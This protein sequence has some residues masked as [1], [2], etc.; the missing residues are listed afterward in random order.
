M[1]KYT[2]VCGCALTLIHMLVGGESDSN[3]VSRL[4]RCA[5]VVRNLKS[6]DLETQR[7]ATA[8]LG[9]LDLVAIPFLRAELRRADAGQHRQAMT[10]QSDALKAKMWETNRPRVANWLSAGRWDMVNELLSTGHGKEATPVLE[11]AAKE[12]GVLSVAFDIRLA[13]LQDPTKPRTNASVEYP[14]NPA[15]LAKRRSSDDPITE[16]K[17]VATDTLDNWV[18]RAEVCRLS[19]KF[20]NGCFLAVRSRLTD[21]LPEDYISEWHRSNLFVNN[22]FTAREVYESLVICDGDFNLNGRLHGIVSSLV[23]CNGDFIAD[24]NITPQS[25]MGSVIYATGDITFPIKIKKPSGSIFFAGGKVHDGKAVA[26]AKNVHEGVTEPPFNVR[27]LDPKEFG[28]T[29]DVAKGGLTVAKLDEKSAF[30]KQ[31]LK[32]GDLITHADDL[33][34]KTVADFRR[35]LRRGVIDGGLLVRVE[36]D[37]KTIPMLFEVPDAPKPAKK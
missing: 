21:A 32:A 6:T 22:G 29:L 30:A 18:L 3:A 20:R 13:S 9:Q 36:R 26:D 31:G 16:M 12:R 25:V 27:F 7:A 28:L 8:A 1:L 35:E 2:A 33:P 19:Y 4:E 15:W 10:K 11:L 23:I 24:E 37:G 5:E 34:M 17:G 14:P